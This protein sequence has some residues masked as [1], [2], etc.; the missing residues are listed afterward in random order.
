MIGK[1]EIG[2]GVERVGEK[3]PPNDVPFFFCVFADTANGC[4]KVMEASFRIHCNYFYFHFCLSVSRI[5]H[6][7]LCSRTKDSSKLNKA[8]SHQFPSQINNLLS[9]F[10]PPFPAKTELRNHKHR[11]TLD[12]K[13]E[14]I[15]FCRSQWT[16]YKFKAVFV[17]PISKTMRKDVDLKFQQ[18]KLAENSKC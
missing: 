9:L 16:Q 17:A 15:I 3:H 11:K 12:Q 7:F 8:F 2:D 6:I 14:L 18:W 10:P 1:L 13:S 5:F 4:T